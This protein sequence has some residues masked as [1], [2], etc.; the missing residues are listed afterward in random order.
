MKTENLLHPIV[1]SPLIVV[2][3]VLFLLVLPLQDFWQSTPFKT[4]QDIMIFQFL[5]V[6]TVVF[7]FRKKTLFLAGALSMAICLLAVFSQVL[8]IK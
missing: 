1:A 2:F 8:F 3:S 4:W 7:I 5:V 6:L